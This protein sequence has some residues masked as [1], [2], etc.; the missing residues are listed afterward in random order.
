MTDV[1]SRPPSRLN[2]VADGRALALVKNFAQTGS[3]S[4]SRPSSPSFG[5]DDDDEGFDSIGRLT[6]G[7]TGAPTN[8]SVAPVAMRAS[9]SSEGQPKTNTLSNRSSSLSDLRNAAAASSSALIRRGSSRRSQ[10]R[11]SKRHLEQAIK[12]A[13]ETLA[14][15]T[16]YAASPETADVDYSG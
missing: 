12:L 3:F 15:E 7:S 9:S 6:C 2:F 8:G 5:D 10:S 11:L 4:S 16:S 13:N 14:A 1:G